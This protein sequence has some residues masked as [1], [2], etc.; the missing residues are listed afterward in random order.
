MRKRFL[1][2]LMAGFVSPCMGLAGEAAP[3]MPGVNVP[4][5]KV[6]T[7]GYLPLWR[8]MAVFNKD[9]QGAVL[10]AEP[11]GAKYRILPAQ[12]QAFGEDPA[13]KDPVWRVDFSG[14][15]ITGH[16]HLEC[17]GA[18]SD[19]F[20]IGPGLY[21]TA[22]KAALKMFYFQRC[23]TALSLPYAQWG[24][25]S[26]VRKGPCHAHD[27][28]GWDL[29]DYP[30]KKNQFRL[31]GGWHDAGNF[32]MYICSTAPTCQ[33]LLMAYERH[34]QLFRDGDVHLPESGKGVPDILSECKWGLL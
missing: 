23:R 28:V 21:A 16:Y 1:F 33:A 27:D 31:T 4:A 12:I 8:K 7:V 13:S 6:D 2:L 30:D 15:T 20:E 5:I 29:S 10:V 32:D 19:S 26:Y 9:P 25:T 17:A 11:S 18:K 22:L 24:N 3:A 34:P 14:L